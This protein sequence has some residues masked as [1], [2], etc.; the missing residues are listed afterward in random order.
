MH[1]P[2]WWYFCLNLQ[3]L[4]WPYGAYIKTAKNGDFF[5][6]LLRENNFEAVLATFFCYD[7]G[8]KSSETVQKI[9]A[10]QK[11]YHKC[12]S[13]VI[14]CWIA[15]IHLSISNSEKWLVTRI[16]PKSLKKLLKLHRGRALTGPLWVLS[17]MEV[18]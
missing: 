12:S 18:R 4:G 14:I 17:I 8:T 7:H 2:H 3:Y 9:A 6:E 13:C 10:G 15:K 11:E 16:P 1:G 5:E